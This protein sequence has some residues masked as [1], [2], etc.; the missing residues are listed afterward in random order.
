M[1]IKSYELKDNLKKNVDF[2]L[3]YG[4]N[5]GLIEETIDNDI[6]N[7]F[8]K[9]VYNY[10]E[11]EV[12]SNRENFEEEI[13]SKSFFESDKLIIISQVTDKIFD[14]IKEL[15]EKKI[16][17]I[18]IILKSGI[19]EKKSKLRIFF[20]KQK[21]LIITPFYE[22][23]LQTLM[24]LAQNFFINNKIRIS[25]QN[26]SYIV[27]KS[28]NNRIILKN[29]LDK[30]KYFS[31]VKKSIEFSD[32]LK[33]IN[34]AENYSLSE[35]AD[36]CLVK[37]K[38]KTLNILNENIP[39]T[40]DNILI[41]KSFLYKLKRLKKLK[42]EIEVKKNQELVISTYK[43]PI[44]WKDKNIIK[45]QLKIWSLEEIKIFIK[46]INELEITIK[47]NNSVA[48]QILNNFILEKLDDVN[49]S[50]L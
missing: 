41:L 45:Q 35:L 49:N 27:E 3:L 37:N 8:S 20:E 28:K 44:F 18:K 19:L 39:S 16:Q 32:I 33:I 17:D 50:I 4:Q 7:H 11:S 36:Q 29:E 34:S 21:N 15:S 30:I 24:T 12:L 14:E 22:D 40:E 31:K 26:I 10:E 13:Y 43:P 46:K 25:P 9:N 48:S 47:K 2:Y 38:R 1:L 5:T 42:E 23:N 6:K